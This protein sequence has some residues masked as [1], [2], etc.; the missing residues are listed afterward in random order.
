MAWFKKA[1]TPI[2]V[3]EKTS[4]VPEGLWIKCPDCGAVLYTKDLAKNSGVCEKCSHHFRLTASERLRVLFDDD[5]WVE[6]D[7]GLASTDPLKFT[8]TTPYAERLVASR[9]ATGQRDAVVVAIGRIEGTEAAVAAMEYGFIGGSMGVVMGEKIVRA[10][11]TA[12]ARRIPMIIV[13]C[14]G[15]ARMMEGALSL[16]QMAKISAALGRLDRAHLP[17]ISVLTDPTTGG[18]TASLAMLGDLNVAEPKALI[19]FA[20]PRVI[21][22]TIGQKLP[23]GFQRSEFLLERGMLDLVVD[24]RELKTTIARALRFMA[25]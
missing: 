9:K 18:V 1:R 7:E 14:S 4:R 10:I 16:M 23:E 8:D 5:R 12:V 2:A 22:Q 21:E 3:P 15:G 6:R 19:G 24:R 11:E 25:A 13:S 20:G 17:Y